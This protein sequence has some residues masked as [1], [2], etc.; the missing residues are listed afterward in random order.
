MELPKVVRIRKKGGVIVQDCDVYIGRAAHQGGWRL[1]ASPWANPYSVRK[2]GRDKALA[3]YR[4]Y[5]LSSP[6]LLAQLPN[7]AG[8]TLG[9]W[10]HPE[11]CHG[12]VIIEVFVDREGSKEHKTNGGQSDGGKRDEAENQQDNDRKRDVTDSEQAKIETQQSDDKKQGRADSKQ[13]SDSQ[14]GSDSQQ[15]HET[16]SQRNDDKKQGG[17]DQQRNNK[18]QD[19][20]EQ[21]K[22]SMN[23]LSDAA[24]KDNL[25]D[26]TKLYYSNDIINEVGTTSILDLPGEI[27]EYLASFFDTES[28]VLFRSAHRQLRSFLVGACLSQNTRVFVERA[29]HHVRTKPQCLFITGP[30]GSGKSTLLRTLYKRSRHRKF[31]KRVLFAATTWRAAV[32]LPQAR[33]VHSVFRINPNSMTSDDVEYTWSYKPKRVALRKIDVFVIDEVSMLPRDVLQYVDMVLRYVHKKPH[34]PFGGKMIVLC[35]DLLQLGPVKGSWFF[36]APVWKEVAFRTICLN[37]PMRQADDTLWFHRLQRIRQGKPTPYDLESLQ[38]L[39]KPMTTEELVNEFVGGRRTPIMFTHRAQVD[40]MNN[41]VLEALEGEE[42]VLK[43]EMLHNGEPQDV[44]GKY[45]IPKSITVKPGALCIITRVCITGDSVLR[46]PGELCEFVSV[47]G[48]T[49]APD[50]I[51]RF[52]SDGTEINLYRVTTAIVLRDFDTRRD[53]YEFFYF[54]I[55]LAYGITIHAA[56]GMTLDKLTAALG[57]SVFAEGQA[58]TALSRVRKAADVTLL[59][60]DP[61]CVKTSRKALKFYEDNKVFEL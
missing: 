43:T 28:F 51:L 33:T 11:P 60:F 36:D 55:A 39:V 52:L 41:A 18:K 48:T 47:G 27:I 29:I 54:P 3:L 44:L 50:I 56:Q 23:T 26:P 12:D 8:K 42:I 9:C 49:I 16:N 40:S 13:S 57:K 38:R 30:A 6:K 22:R 34:T 15:R 58:Y 7:L 5:L 19:G 2:H 20:K 46:Y 4:S 61:S 24:R 45:E 31:G 1:P 59:E 14:Q 17:L 35:G 53:V 32:L 25:E 37:V 10:C 21:K